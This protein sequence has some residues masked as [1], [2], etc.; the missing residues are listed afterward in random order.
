MGINIAFIKIYRNDCLSPLAKD[1]HAI[2]I[3]ESELESNLGGFSV[4]EIGIGKELEY[5][6][7]WNLNGTMTQISTSGAS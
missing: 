6:V 1:V 3:P 7:G 2:P 5:F 4:S